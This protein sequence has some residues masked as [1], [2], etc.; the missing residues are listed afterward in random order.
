MGR[1]L[2]ATNHGNRLAEWSR[3]VEAC[4]SSDLSVAQWCRENGIAVSSYYQWQRKVFM[5]FSEGTETSFAEIAPAA[6][7]SGA[8]A[9]AVQ[10]GEFRA[11][12]YSGA[13]EETI[14]AVLHALRPC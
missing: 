13:D 11:E 1:N 4:R 7:H 10:L 12:I 8:V 2:Q 5:A 3:R 14:R 6:R 9:A